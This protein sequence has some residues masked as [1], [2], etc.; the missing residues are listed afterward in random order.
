MSLLLF[1]KF[2]TIKHFERK[3]IVDDW[4]EINVAAH[5]AVTIRAIRTELDRLLSSYFDRF[6]GRPQ[7]AAWSPSDTTVDS[8]VKLLTHLTIAGRSDVT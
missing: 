6:C 3:V 7:A 2:L 5:T 1:A 4:I 8:I